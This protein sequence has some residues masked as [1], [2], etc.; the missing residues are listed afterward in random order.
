MD[1]HEKK[2]NTELLI[3]EFQYFN[4]TRDGYKDISIIRHLL[5][6]IFRIRKMSKIFS[7]QFSEKEALDKLI[8]A[9]Q[10]YRIFLNEKQEEP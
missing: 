9:A 2:T 4:F 10:A 5:K 8:E 6:T 7:K 1:K 3:S